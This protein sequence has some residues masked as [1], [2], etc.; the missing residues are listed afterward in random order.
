MPGHIFLYL[1]EDKILI[2]GDAVCYEED[3]LVICN[4]QFTLD[5]KNA[6]ESI[7]KL[8]KYEIN[9]I[10][11]YHGGIVKTNIKNLFRDLLTK[12]S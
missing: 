9:E 11:C 10:I 1:R 8:D 7:K 12:Q 3:Q 4:P 5:M 6:F 2:A